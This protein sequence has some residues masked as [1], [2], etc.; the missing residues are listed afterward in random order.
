MTQLDSYQ[1][2]FDL[3]VEKHADQYDLRGGPYINHVLA[4]AAETLASTHAERDSDVVV[5]ALLHDI[6]EDTDVTLAQIRK[7]FGRD[8]A[9]VVDHLTR[10]SSETYFDYIGRAASH[11]LAR[12]VKLADNKVNSWDVPTESLAKRYAKARRILIASDRV[13]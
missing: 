4:V 11:P 6:I 7:A 12:V 1:R 8:V 2:A 9:D 10:R 5:A 3:A 13:A